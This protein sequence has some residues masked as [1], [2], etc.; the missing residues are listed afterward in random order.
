M[1]TTEVLLETKRFRVVRRAQLLADGRQHAREV[2]LHPGA[3][4]I[5][6]LVD[7]DRVCLIS[8]YRLAVEQWLI[9]IPAG[10][11]EPGE[12]PAATA[13]R[14][15]TEETGYQAGT[16]VP[17]CQMLFSPGILNERMHLF[18]ASD[19]RPGPTRLEVGEQ[20]ETLI[21]PWSEALEMIH[22][23]EIEDAKTVAALLHCDR[24]KRAC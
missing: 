4:G 14:E 18:V 11:L 19:L 22:R 17:L 7:G 23:G 5:V 12:D 16:L 24:W 9:E 15:L 21:V 10:T 2:I 3:V 8:N 6:P 13:R 20:I 1:N